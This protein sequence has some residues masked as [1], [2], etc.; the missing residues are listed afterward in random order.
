MDCKVLE[1]FFLSRLYHIRISVGTCIC[2]TLSGERFCIC[3]CFLL[4]FE[5][6]SKQVANFIKRAKCSSISFE[7]NSVENGL[8]TVPYAGILENYH[9]RSQD[10]FSGGGNTFSKKFSKNFQKIFKKF[11]KNYSKIFQK[12]SKIF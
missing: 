9:G 2:W 5:N 11:S 1:F 4:N 8:S 6:L 10:L 12:I 3:S 7:Q